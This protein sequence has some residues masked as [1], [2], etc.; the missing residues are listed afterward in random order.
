MGDM[1][2][3]MWIPDDVSR[4]LDCCWVLPQRFVARPYM[5]ISE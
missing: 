1:K 4:I 2:G 5:N 3:W